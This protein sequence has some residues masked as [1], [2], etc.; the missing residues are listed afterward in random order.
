MV[1]LR[2]LDIFDVIASEMLI[3][4]HIVVDYHRCHRNASMITVLSRLAE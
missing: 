1:N 3:I 2:E 4:K